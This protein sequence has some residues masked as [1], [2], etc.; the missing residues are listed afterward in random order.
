MNF[1]ALSI[2]PQAKR[3]LGSVA[4]SMASNRKEATDRTRFRRGSLG[5]RAQMQTE[6]KNITPSFTSWEFPRRT[7]KE[8]TRN[9]L[10]PQ[11]SSQRH[12]SS[13]SQSQFHLTRLS[14]PWFWGV[15]DL[16]IGGAPPIPSGSL[17]R[18][19]A[20]TESSAGDLDLAGVIC[21]SDRC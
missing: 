3:S 15:P 21:P 8:A 17:G 14:S 2:T 18:A 5:S 4:E 16:G 9:T 7:A 13:P 20:K 11:S 10:A 1:E 19:A 12:L 6:M